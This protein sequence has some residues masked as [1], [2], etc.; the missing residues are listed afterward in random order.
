MLTTIDFLMVKLIH[1]KM[2]RYIE[3]SWILKGHMFF[4][5]KYQSVQLMGS[6]RKSGLSW[7]GLLSGSRSSKI[8]SGSVWSLTTSR[9][10]TTQLWF[11]E[12]L[13]LA[14]RCSFSCRKCT[15][16]GTL[17]VGRRSLFRR[18]K[19]RPALAKNEFSWKE[20]IKREGPWFH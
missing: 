2:A 1:F 10:I 8:M 19:P 7:A 14:V 5:L 4:K 11:Q 3:I 12:E 15:R 20:R 9:P 18:A 17:M 13:W 16:S 6:S